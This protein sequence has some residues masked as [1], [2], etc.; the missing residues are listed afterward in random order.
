MELIVLENQKAQSIEVTITNDE[1]VYDYSADLVKSDPL[2]DLAILKINDPKFSSNI[3]ISNGIRSRGVRVGEEAFALGYPLTFIMGEEVKF[4]D[5]RISSLTGFQG[6]IK[7]FQTTIAIQPGNSGGPMIDYQGNLL[8]ITTSGLNKNVAENVSY[9][10][11]ATNLLDLIEVLPFDIE[12]P[13]EV[14]SRDDLPDLVER[15][16]KQTVFIK[17]K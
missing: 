11:K 1:G 5:G 15:L 10:V 9:S 13:G 2:I 12:L 6:D 16:A 7:S 4:T 8:G 14:S 17:V 3:E